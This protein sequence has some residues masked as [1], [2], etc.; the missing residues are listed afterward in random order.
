[1]SQFKLGRLPRTFDS[2]VPHLSAYLGARKRASGRPISVD[3]S[4]EK[5]PGLGVYHN[6]TLGDC[7]IAA[8]YHALQVW[9]GTAETLDFEPQDN[10]ILLYEQACGYVPGNPS[11]DNGGIEQ[12]VLQYIMNTGAP[13]GPNGEHRHRIAA[14]VEVDPRNQDDIKQTIWECGVCYIGFNVP[15]FLMD[16]YTIPDSIWTPQTTDNQIIGGHAVVLA[17]Y[18]TFGAQ[19]ISW[20][21][22]YR[23]SWGFFSQYVDEA[24]ALADRD[25]IESTGRS[26]AGLT[27][28]ELETAMKSLKT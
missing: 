20:G 23:M 15:Q 12:N 14:Y 16:K 9:S 1:M 19:V 17:G 26:P 8:V 5:L 27:L 7:T 6:D 4:L 24:Y 28:A 22:R 21:S 13:M 11:T 3:Y 10:A 18:D 2:R 25:W